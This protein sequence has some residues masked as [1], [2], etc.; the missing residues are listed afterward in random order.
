MRLNAS[1]RASTS[2]SVAIRADVGIAR[3]GRILIVARSQR[4]ARQASIS[5]EFYQ[6]VCAM[7]GL[8]TAQQG[9]RWNLATKMRRT[10]GVDDTQALKRQQI[11]RKYC[12]QRPITGVLSS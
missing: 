1:A 7:L 6:Y 5:P 2:K 4:R 8:A 9:Y 11:D 12:A 10:R 3:A